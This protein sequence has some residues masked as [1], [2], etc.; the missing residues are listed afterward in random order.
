MPDPVLDSGKTEL[1]VGVPLWEIAF[2]RMVPAASPVPPALQPCD[3]ATLH[4]W[5]ES[6]PFPWNLGGLCDCFDQQKAEEVLTA[7]SRSSENHRLLPVERSPRHM[8]RVHVS[9]LET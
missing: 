9:A 8:D 7:E 3:L 6:V 2:P 5:L 4:P 1:Q